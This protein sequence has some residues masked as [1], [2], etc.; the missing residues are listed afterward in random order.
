MVGSDGMMAQ[1][2]SIRIALPR[3][4][5][6]K[7]AVVTAVRQVEDPSL[8]PPSICPGHDRSIR[9]RSFRRTTIKSGAQN[10]LQGAKPGFHPLQ[11]PLPL[12]L[13]WATVGDQGF[14]L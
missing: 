5:Q 7:R 2:R 10:R 1:Q 4:L 9:G 3:E 11:A 14:P 6:Q 8:S 12:S 13:L